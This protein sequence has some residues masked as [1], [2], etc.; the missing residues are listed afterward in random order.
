VGVTVSRPRRARSRRPQHT[1][2][3]AT[4][5]RL[6]RRDG[7]WLVLLWSVCGLLCW[8]VGSQPVAEPLAFDVE[9]QPPQVQLRNFHGLERS[10]AGSYRWAKPAAFFTLPTSAPGEYRIALVIG[11]APAVGTPRAA[12][13]YANGAEVAT[14]P[15]TGSEQTVAFTYRYTPAAWATSGT[16]NHNLDIELITTPFTPPGDDRAL[17]V[18][19]YRATVSPGAM[20]LALFGQLLPGFLIVG[21][22]YVG[23]RLARW[24]PWLAVVP[25]LLPLTGLLLFAIDDRRAALA[26][27]LRLVLSPWP[28]LALILGPPAAYLLLRAA[29]AAPLVLSAGEERF[30]SR[31]TIPLGAVVALGA[32]LR[33]DRLNRLSLWSDEG[34]TIFIAQRPWRHV[35]GLDGAY[36][37]HP[38]LHFALVKGMMLLFP[39][40]SAG[41]ILS[42]LCGV[43]TI[44][45]LYALASRLVGRT[46]ALIAALALTIAPLH[47]WYSQEARMYAPAALAVGCSYLAVVGCA[48]AERR[49]HRWGWAALYAVSL[50]LAMYLVYSA[51]Y[52]LLPQL[53]LLGVL[54]WRQ[55]EHL[56]PL[57]A[58]GALAVLAYLPWLPQLART[59]ETLGPDRALYLS[60]T[61]R[62]VSTTLLSLTGLHGMSTGNSYYSGLWEQREPWALLAVVLPALILGAIGWARST[63]SAAL[64]VA[65]LS[66]GT[67]TSAIVLSLISPGF[68]PRT[69]LFAALGWAML[70]GGVWILRGPRWFMVAARLLLVAALVVP[71]VTWWRMRQDGYKEP[72]RDMAL[73]AAEAVGFGQPIVV[74]DFILPAFVEAYAPHLAYQP[75]SYLSS[76][77]ANG[78]TPP[79]IW[80]VY[81]E[82]QDHGKVLR[83]RLLDLGYERLLHRHPGGNF[84]VDL[85]A[86]PGRSPGEP[87]LAGAAVAG[88][89]WQ[90]PTGGAWHG[91][92]TGPELALR[93]ASGTASARLDLPAAPG[94]LYTLEIAVRSASGQGEPLA[95][96]SCLDAAGVEL[97]RSTTR[98]AQLP[99]RQ[100]SQ[101]AASDWRDL[102]V[103]VLCPRDTASVRITLESTVAV[104]SQF[105]NLA[106]WRLAGGSA[107]RERVLYSR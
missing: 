43:L 98:T 38:P 57:V 1:A 105:R 20:P 47:V 51:L 99:P 11:D 29:L 48:Q 16:A 39:I 59:T 94:H 82:W 3:G 85:F 65:A 9:R 64:A 54:L 62:D 69:V 6:L 41:R 96:V 90:L 71:G 63:A 4:A 86:R 72:T 8:L 22:A 24:R 10:A 37:S 36:D 92:P 75:Q 33:V 89:A 84:F 13:I 74:M 49:A 19:F 101:Q 12:R 52:P 15:L 30:W 55:R 100:S 31:R 32:V 27:V 106:L 25:P 67:I 56:L 107:V 50:A 87:V 35:L 79:A 5:L 78:T 70:V 28:G 66:V 45:V 81:A 58:G 80:L 95:G 7:P 93:D 26:L 102:R 73:A 97:A 68:A 104:E 76:L 103:A 53:A 77:P 40:H 2:Q 42:A 17:G 34:I 91:A 46:P 14:V 23:L 61:L 83:Q 18:I 60:P 44:V 21:L 88:A